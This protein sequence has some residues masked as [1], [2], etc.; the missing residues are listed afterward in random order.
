MFSRPPSPAG[1]LKPLRRKPFLQFSRIGLFYIMAMLVM[2]L[3]ATNSQANLLF[4]VF[5]LMFGV[6]L[7]AYAIN[8]G[9][10][11]KLLIHR[12]FPDYAVVG[13]ST[14]LSYEC[15][16][17]KRFWPS[18][19]VLVSELDGAEA[20]VRSPVAYMLHAAP[21]MTAVVPTEVIPLRRGLCTFDR[22]EAVSTF[23]FGF[24]RRSFVVRQEENLLIYPA[25]AKVAP[26]LLH[27]CQSAQAG[28]ANARPRRGGQDE[29]Y[30]IK[31]FRPGDNPRLIHWKRSA[32]T[33][34]LVAK[35]MTLI[36]PPCL[37]LLVDTQLPS[38]L[39]AGPM[40]VEKVIAMA[41]SLATYALEAGMLVGVY[42]WNDPWT[43][44][45]PSRGQRHR[46]DVMTLLARLPINQSHGADQLLG[47][48]QSMLKSN[49][50]AVLFS[51]QKQNFSLA[52]SAQDRFL[53]ISPD[54]GQSSAWFDFDKTVDFAAAAPLP[55]DARALRAERPNK[56]A[57]ND[58][59]RRRS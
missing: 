30:G 5:G 45:A 44:V 27:K 21:G 39:A 29:F 47:E 31:E 22:L 19:S 49:A 4:A 16:N 24:L 12:V 17:G 52:A 41:A 20:F 28:A 57:K 23:P 7:I 32:S 36:A 56:Q 14:V 35:E 54:D 1:P 40:Q 51:P 15:K 33:G 6:L 18:L 2:Y 53:A 26:A 50:T 3:A 34:F 37:L 38:G 43:G 46:R 25:L 42:A 58:A 48:A 59:S 11:R 8:W 10:L 13:Q 9:V 55:Q